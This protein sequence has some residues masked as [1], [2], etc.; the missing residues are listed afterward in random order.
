[1]LVTIMDEGF[2]L[3]NKFR[4]VVFD[5][6]AAGENNIDQIMK[7]HHLIRPVVNRVLK[8]FIDGGI[9]EKQGNTY[10]FTPEG[11]KLVTSMEK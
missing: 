3:S 4:K 8:E 10:R 9:L 7:R 6:F 5:A 11:E 2:I 1:M